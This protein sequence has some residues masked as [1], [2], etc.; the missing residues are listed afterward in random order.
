MKGA[1]T[2]PAF[3]QS[4]VSTSSL[5]TTAEDTEQRELELNFRRTLNVKAMQCNTL[6]QL[7]R[8][9]VLHDNS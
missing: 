4:L 7:I 6:I 9:Y 1:S 3:S 2:P 8:E 5:E